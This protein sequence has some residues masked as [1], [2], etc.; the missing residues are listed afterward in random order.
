[1]EGC[2]APIFGASQIQSPL[3]DFL[4]E[5]LINS[6]FVLDHNSLEYGP[7]A[8]SIFNSRGG[9]D[10]VNSTWARILRG[11]NL[12]APYPLSEYSV[13]SGFKF[14]SKQKAVES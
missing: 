9:P 12:L 7:S 3:V 2:L 14:L 4:S 11:Q 1:M 10:Q 6:L 5:A 13:K 8:S